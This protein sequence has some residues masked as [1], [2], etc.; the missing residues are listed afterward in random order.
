MSGG[1]TKGPKH[2]SGMLGMTKAGTPFLFEGEEY[3]INAKAAD[4]LGEEQ[5]DLL[6]SMR[7]NKNQAKASFF[8]F[9]QNLGEH[10]DGVNLASYNTKQKEFARNKYAKLQTSGANGAWELLSINNPLASITDPDSWWIKAYFDLLGDPA[11]DISSNMFGWGGSLGG[12]IKKATAP[13]RNIQKQIN[14]ILFGGGGG[15]GGGGSAPATPKKP[16]RKEGTIG[17][18]TVYPDYSLVPSSM[19]KSQKF[20][21]LG[22]MV[23]N[24][25]DVDL[26]NVSNPFTYLVRGIVDWVR[27]Q[28]WLRWFWEWVL[29]PVYG[30]IEKTLGPDRL[31]VGLD[32]S[33]L[34][35][36][37]SYLDINFGGNVFEELGIER[38]PEAKNK[39]KGTFKKKF[40]NGGMVVG[41]SHSLGGYNAE[42]EGGEYVI[43]K[44]AAQAFGYANLERIN[45]GG[46]PASLGSDA[47]LERIATHLENLSQPEIHVHVYTDMRGE[48][49]AE[50]DRFKYEVR[51]K[52]ERTRPFTGEKYVPLSA[53]T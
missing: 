40:S 44:Q 31:K 48:A 13:I 43:Q 28:E 11:L 16:P 2:K 42:L 38:K 45:R 6:N 46:S 33:M 21:F 26:I 23:G 27:E 36:W 20:D 18:P 53:L 17:N 50:I 49:K 37:N 7:G 8:Q 9:I 52:G 5:L 24:D 3:I 30:W 41:P 29:K 12:I 47:L 15:G 19:K 34:D 14:K 10:G 51:Q 32:G 39:P 35:F 4:F 22:D 1:K 25:F